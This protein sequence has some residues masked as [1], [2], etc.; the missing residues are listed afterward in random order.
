MAKVFGIPSPHLRKKSLHHLYRAVLMAFG[1]FS[2]MLILLQ[3]QSLYPNPMLGFLMTYTSIVVLAVLGYKFYRED[4]AVSENYYRGRKGESAILEELQKLPDPFRVFCDVTTQPPYNID[5]VV[6]GPTGIFTVE[7]KSHAG[8]V[9]YADGRIT[10]NGAAPQEKD[11]LKQAKSEA[12][13]VA[14]ALKGKVSDQPWVYPVI[15]FSHPSAIPRFG[16]TP[17]DGVFVVGKAFLTKLL[18][19]PRPQSYSE[20]TVLELEHA[21]ESLNNHPQTQEITP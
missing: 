8:Q 1:G 21:L 14:D 7:A 3:A 11:F 4:D 16:L 15:A 10:I 12:L 19:E 2:M 13:S 5:F 20:E 18:I 6:I 9:G 17:V